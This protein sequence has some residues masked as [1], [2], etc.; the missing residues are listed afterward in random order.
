MKRKPATAA[1]L[2]TLIPGLGQIYLGKGERGAA[3][4]IA[5]IIVGN[6]NAIWLTL[7]AQPISEID[8]FWATGLPRLLHDLFAFYGMVFIVWQIW[9]AYSGGEKDSS[10]VS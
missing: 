7:Y 1:L 4:L 8:S 3:I 6:L 2:S 5:T 9:D 10:K